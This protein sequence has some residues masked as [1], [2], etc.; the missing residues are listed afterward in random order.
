M[1][2]EM[3][4]AVFMLFKCSKNSVYRSSNFDFTLVYLRASDM[5]DFKVF[6]LNVQID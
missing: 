1:L 4:W 2:K 3:H 5:F 6:T